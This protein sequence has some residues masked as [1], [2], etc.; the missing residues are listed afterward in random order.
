MLQLLLATSVLIGK[1]EVSPQVYQYDLM[2]E[3]QE[4]K[5]VVCENNL[6]EVTK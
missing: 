5:T 4:V 6:C 3:E 1:V 2:I